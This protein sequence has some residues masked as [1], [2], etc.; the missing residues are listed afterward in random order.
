MWQEQINASGDR[1]Y[2]ISSQPTC[3]PVHD[4]VADSPCGVSILEYNKDGG[5][6][7]TKNDYN[8]TTI[9][10]WHLKSMS[11][12]AVL[13]HHLPIKRIQWHP[14]INDLLLIH[15]SVTEPVI[16]LWKDSWEVPKVISLHLDRRSKKMEASWLSD[17]DGLSSFMLTSLHN[18]AIGR[19]NKEGELKS[20]S[21]KTE[22]GAGPEE[23]FDEG[24]SLDLSPL[25]ESQGDMLTDIQN[26]SP[27]NEHLDQWTAPDEADDTF[28]Y[29]RQRKAS[30]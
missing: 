22:V 13:I 17:S 20:M 26:R 6:L 12:A 30:I 19:I 2:L 10:I 5:L 23:M 18:F 1:S 4:L 24:N 8:P 3:P 25:K 21:G 15:S 28:E 16:H 11:A 9:W 29:R 14:L 7:A 27:G